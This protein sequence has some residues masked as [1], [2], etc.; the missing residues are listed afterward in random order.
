MPVR[1][2]LLELNKLIMSSPPHNITVCVLCEEE[3]SSQK[4]PMMSCS[5]IE[6]HNARQLWK[7]NLKSLIA[8]A[9]LDLRNYMEEFYFN[10]FNRQDGEMAAVGTYTVRWVNQLNKDKIFSPTDW[11]AML[12]LMK[13]VAQGARGVMRVYTRACCDKTRERGKLAKGYTRALELRQLSIGEF[14]GQDIANKPNSNN[15]NNEIVCAPPVGTLEDI[16]RGGL[17]LVGWRR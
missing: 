5:A 16:E 17:G 6:V 9:R 8:K 12:G 15:K 2:V 4:H 10:V 11:K 13:T 1:V 7:G 14:V 3:F